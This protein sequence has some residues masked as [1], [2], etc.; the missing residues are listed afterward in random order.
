VT[1]HIALGISGSERILAILRKNAEEI[2]AAT[3]TDEF[4]PAAE[5]TGREWKLG[6]ESVT[7]SVRRK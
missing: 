7:V 2:G 5:E 3:L 6:D 1:D 4:L